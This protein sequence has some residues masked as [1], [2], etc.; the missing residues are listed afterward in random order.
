MLVR[1]L[2]AI[3]AGSGCNVGDNIRILQGDFVKHRGAHGIVLQAIE[4]SDMSIQLLVRLCEVKNV[5]DVCWNILSES[6]DIVAWAP[7]QVTSATCWCLIED[8]TLVL[9][10]P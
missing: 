3:A 6:A 9:S 4:L 7:E 2:A 8:R 1:P 5:G 10:L